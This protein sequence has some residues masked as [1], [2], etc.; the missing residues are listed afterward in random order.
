MKEFCDRLAKKEPVPGGGSVC[1]YSAS[2]AVGLIVMVAQ[3]SKGKGKS[4]RVENRIEGILKRGNTI[5]LRLMDLVD[6]DAQAYAGVV[7]ARGKGKREQN[8]AL[9]EARKVPMEVGKL[10]L[11]AVD[12]I[13]FLVLNGSKYLLSDLEVAAELLLSAHSGALRLCRSNG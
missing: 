7:Q 3:Y 11:K 4:R 6:L 8:R 13:P 1:A 9:R 2:V 5:R 10:C 12:L